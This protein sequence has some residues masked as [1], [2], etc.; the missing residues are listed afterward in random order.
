MS[1]FKGKYNFWSQLLVSIIAFCAMPQVSAVETHSFQNQSQQTAAQQIQQRVLKSVVQRQTQIFQKEYRKRA[2]G[3]S[4][5][6]KNAPHF[7][8]QI[9]FRSQP[10][11][12]GPQV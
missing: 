8:E 11:R 6:L 4:K 3:F 9:F 7:V 10:I 12:A 1:L 5:V 2:V